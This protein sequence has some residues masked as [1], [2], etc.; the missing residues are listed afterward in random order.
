MAKSSVDI[1]IN[2][3][4]N[5][6]KKFKGVNK[7][8]QGLAASLKSMAGPLAAVAAGFLAFKSIKGIVSGGIA[9]FAEQEKAVLDLTAALKLQGAETES[10]MPELKQFASELQALT[11]VGDEATLATMKQ[12]TLLGVQQDELKGATQAVI[13]LKEAGMSE[14]AATKALA[15]AREGDFAALQRYIPALKT[16]TTE[17][18]KMDAV[19]KMAADGFAIA[20]R[21][22]ETM[23]GALQA[24]KNSWG[25]TLE[26]VGELLAPYITKIADAFNRI[27]PMIQEKIGLLL[28]IMEHIA[29]RAAEIS[30]WLF[31]QLVKGYTMIETVIQ[32]FGDTVNLIWTMI[33][34]GVTK[35]VNDIV[36]FF[37]E[38]LPQI[39]EW[40]ADNWTN[41][42]RDMFVAIGTFYLNY[43]KMIMNNFVIL[44][45]F[46]KSGMTGGIGSLMTD[47]GKNMGQNLLDGFEATTKPLPKA[48]ARQMTEGEKELAS[49]AA[50]L[51]GGIA[52]EYN[53]KVEERLGFFGDAFSMDLGAG[54]KKFEG[55]G[56]TEGA[57]TRAEEKAAG[58]GGGK[59]AAAESRFLTRGSGQVS[60][61]EQMV[62]QQKESKALLAQVNQ[63]ITQA[64][65][66]LQG[67]FDKDTGSDVE[68]IQ[69]NKGG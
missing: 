35:L 63:G 31:E 16:A 4:D 66:F 61:E 17:A 7:E 12:L 22:T 54:A 3:K 65:G 2:A 32:N 25:D 49:K 23:G 39:G 69:S 41:L 60:A 36:Y 46:I 13:G 30:Y 55:I 6:S 15:L 45:K 19:N 62:E 28:P 1:L 59:L 8:S 5:A 50:K 38:R 21:G 11:N 9:A 51:A 42:F 37:T 34:L 56:F 18:E 20:S 27:A 26:S 57:K 48:I 10:L 24:L 53:E 43:I 14:A 44:F 47:L 58:K 52:N 40:F 29:T 68:I 67:I 64:V 33:K